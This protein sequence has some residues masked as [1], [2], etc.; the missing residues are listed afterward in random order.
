LRRF[1]GTFGKI[2]RISSYY[3]G[4]LRSDQ[5][6]GG[7][8]KQTRGPGNRV[9]DSTRKTGD[10][11]GFPSKNK[12]HFRDYLTRETCRP[13]N[14]NIWEGSSPVPG[15]AGENVLSLLVAFHSRRGEARRRWCITK[16]LQRQEEGGTRGRG[17]GSKSGLEGQRY[18]AGIHFLLR[19]EEGRGNP[20]GASQQGGLKRAVLLIVAGWMQMKV[21]EAWA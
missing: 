13:Y 4:E 17:S 1:T 12:C 16:T 6:V 18:T 5:V 10:Y 3:T 9:C 20:E 2:N 14:K 19:Q 11:K 7:R 8:R 15:R 21:D